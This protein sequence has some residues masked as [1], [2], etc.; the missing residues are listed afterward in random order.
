MT[1]KNNVL[2]KFL[3]EEQIANLPD[4]N[5]RQSWAF[6]PYLQLANDNVQN[7]VEIMLDDLCVAW[8][9]TFE[10]RKPSTKT[11]QHFIDCANVIMANLLRAYCKNTNM[12]VG[13]HRRKDRLDR[14]RRYR[15][16][17]MTANRF[18]MAQDWLMKFGHMQLVRRGYN[19][20]NEGQTTRVAITDKAATELEAHELTLRDF[21][22]SRPDEAI[23]LKGKDDQLCRYEDNGKTEAMRTALDKINTLL[24]N[25]VIST[26]RTLTRLDRKPSYIGK[27]VYLGRIFNYGSFETGGRF[28]G[29]WWQYIRKHARRLILL[30]GVST[31]EAD[32]R[33]FNPSMLLAKADLPIPNDPYSL[34]PGVSDCE[35]LRDHAKTTLAA[36]LNSKTGRTDQPKGFDTGRHGMTAEDFRLS[37]H[38]AFPMLQVL[39]GQNVGMKLQRAESDLAEQVMLH[40][41]DQGHPILPIHDAF[42]VQENLKDELVQVMQDTF[43]TRYGQIPPVKVI[44]PFN[45]VRS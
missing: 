11:Q 32:Y 12:T 44:L 1:E 22:I 30:D 27:R 24:S 33:G 4:Q 23:L 31:V 42:M 10:V 20:G 18:I 36:L 41:V 40:F 5:V 25:T 39:L 9:A 29:G 21:R 2:R 17:Y 35:E 38:D 13:I 14:E 45:V 43:K 37:V 28:Y 16:E 6:E 26:T 7:N 8:M 34:I 15:P 19:F 3:S